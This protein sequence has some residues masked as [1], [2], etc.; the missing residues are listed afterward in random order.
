MSDDFPIIVGHVG[1]NSRESYRVSIGEYQGHRYLDLRIV[2][3]DGD[4]SM[5][6][7]QKGVTIKFSTIPQLLELLRD[8]LAE[9]KRR[10]LT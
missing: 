7:T 9:A 1:K 2:V 5:K 3:P 8:G 6:P 10:G 4:G